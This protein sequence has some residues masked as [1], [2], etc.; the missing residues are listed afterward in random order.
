MRANTPLKVL[1]WYEFI[2]ELTN[3]KIILWKHV[4]PRICVEMR[5]SLIT[6]AARIDY[7]RRR[8]KNQPKQ[9]RNNKKR[10]FIDVN[11][12]RCVK[13]PNLYWLEP[14]MDES[15]TEHWATPLPVCTKIE[16]K[17]IGH[18]P[19]SRADRGAKNSGARCPL[20]LTEKS[21]QSHRWPPLSSTARFPGVRRCAIGAN[22]RRARSF[23]A[24]ILRRRAR[25]AAAIDGLGPEKQVVFLNNN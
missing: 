5:P 24:R 11:N 25:I 1:I 3:D 23:S 18:D 4:G 21:N 16:P 7:R 13:I 17:S 15:R 9:S 22:S 20:M 10:A 12:T 6:T 2:D 8:K 19:R 14:I